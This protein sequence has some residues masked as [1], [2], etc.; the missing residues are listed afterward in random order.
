MEMNRKLH[1]QIPARVSMVG[2]QVR[3]GTVSGVVSV[4]TPDIL[5]YPTDRPDIFIRIRAGRCEYRR[6]YRCEEWTARSGSRQGRERMTLMNAFDVV[7]VRKQ[8]P[9]LDEGAAH[10]DG[11]GGLATP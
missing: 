7:A 9:A 2:S 5:H 6:E 8:F 3:T 1:P 11:P 4:L 10:F